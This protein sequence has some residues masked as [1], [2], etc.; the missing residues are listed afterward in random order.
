MP[1]TPP[2]TVASKAT[3]GYQSQ[4]LI[5]TV[6]SPLSYNALAELKSF[7]PNLISVPDVPTTHLLSPSN[8]EE[9]IPAMIKPGTIDVSGNFIGDSSQLA[10]TAL[11]QAQTVFAFKATAPMQSGTKTYTLTGVGFINK[12]ETGP[13]E[14][15]KGIE[16]SASIQMT[17]T[18]TEAVA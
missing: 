16:F 14:I 8:T 18:Y 12:Y 6:A 9:M 4:L 11:A 1:F 3:T 7:K 13:F 15:N 17:G 10:I 2:T 5:G